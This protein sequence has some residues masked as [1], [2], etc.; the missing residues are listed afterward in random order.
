MPVAAELSLSFIVEACQVLAGVL[1]NSNAWKKATNE[2]S[3]H[4]ADTTGIGVQRRS[5]RKLNYLPFIAPAVIFRMTLGKI[6]TAKS[7]KRKPRTKTAETGQGSS[8]RSKKLAAVA[9]AHSRETGG[10]AGAR[11]TD[12]RRKRGKSETAIAD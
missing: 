9:A 12:P 11:K 4:P 2:N 6:M 10:W 7:T 3:L 8:P 1:R 5:I